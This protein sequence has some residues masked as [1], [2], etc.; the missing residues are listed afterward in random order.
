M[1]AVKP[2]VTKV[3]PVTKTDLT[4]FQTK[5]VQSSRSR[6]AKMVRAIGIKLIRNTVIWPG[7]I[8]RALAELKLV[9][10]RII[11]IRCQTSKGHV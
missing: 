2:A 3:E 6:V 10:V 11:R 8:V 1:H 5:R 9:K 4:F 7:R